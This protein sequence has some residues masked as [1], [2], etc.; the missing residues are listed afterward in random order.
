MN[1]SIYWNPE[2]SADIWGEQEP[3]VNAS[4]LCAAANE[5]IDQFIAANP[6]ADDTEISE[7]RAELWEQYCETDEINGVRSI[8]AE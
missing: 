7:F 4:E 2:M 1:N 5:M 3:P 8:W 6:D